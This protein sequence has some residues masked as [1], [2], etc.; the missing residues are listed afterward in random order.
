MISETWNYIKV[1]HSKGV[2]DDTGSVIKKIAD[3]A[4]A[5]EIDICDEEIL[6]FSIKQNVMILF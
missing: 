5:Q 2:L 3:K 1:G 4:V 6:L